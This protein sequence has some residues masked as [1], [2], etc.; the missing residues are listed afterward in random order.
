MAVRPGI[1]GIDEGT[2]GT[3]AA[4]VLADGSI[5]PVFYEPLMVSTPDG[6]RVEQ[7]AGEI[8]AKTSDVARQARAWAEANGVQLAG[9]SIANQR[10]TSVLWDLRDGTPLAPAVVWQDRRYA[11]ELADLAAEWDDRLIAATGRPVGTRSPL[12]WLTRC[13]REVPA[14][15]DAFRARR[16][17]FGTVDAWLLHQLTAGQTRTFS[18]TNAQSIGGLV[19]DDLTW[20]PGWLAALGVP[21]GVL[22]VVTNDAGTLG[23]T[24]P[25]VLGER[26][27][28]AAAVGDQHAAWVALGADRA[29]DT[30]VVHGT[31][32]FVSMLTGAPPA[33]SH[34]IDNAL[35]EIAWRTPTDSR[36]AVEAFAATTGAAVDWLCTGIGL[37][38]GPEQL[39]ALAASAPHAAAPWFE[40]SLAGVRTPVADPSATGLLG[41][42]TL[43]T[44]KAAI[45]RAVVDGVAHTVGDLVEALATVSGAAPRI[46]RC[47][48]GLARSDVLA[49]AQAD[50]LGVPVERAADFD[51]ASLRGA[52]YLAGIELG[53][54]PDRAAALGTLPGGD[55]FEPRISAQERADLRGAWQVATRRPTTEGER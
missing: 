2:T 6:R 16:L 13:I 10:A 54:W 15:A 29:G 47:G 55:L 8:W 39:G 18:A 53:V 1:L 17:A 24:D 48:G 43:A 50:L 51:T 3:R 26:L 46:L 5:G 20:L 40:P 37:F 33:A 21:G 49:Q 35:Y 28:I 7:D 31:G 19:L 32:S 12:L 22:P 9:L 23:T 38:S 41:G 25:G 14:V 52:A 42:L 27:P 45:A 11:D 4:V 34:E 44:D 30:T 36:D